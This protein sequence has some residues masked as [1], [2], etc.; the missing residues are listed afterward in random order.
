[1]GFQGLL[2]MTRLCRSVWGTS[3]KKKS[4]LQGTAGQEQKKQNRG[5]TGCAV[6]W[7]FKTKCVGARVLASCLNS[8]G[9]QGCWCLHK[10]VLVAS[11]C[12][13]GT[14]ALCL[15][16]LLTRHAPGVHLRSTR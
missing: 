1:M 13:P 8:A 6:Q 16:H 2:S 4:Y 12:T 5:F 7:I 9:P 14:P 3:S 10:G 15:Q 11:T